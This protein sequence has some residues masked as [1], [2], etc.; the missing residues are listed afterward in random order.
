M[1]AISVKKRLHIHLR[2][3]DLGHFGFSYKLEY[4]RAQFDTDIASVTLFCINNN[5]SAL[6]AILDWW[7]TSSFFWTLRSEKT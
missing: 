3:D 7:S 6:D 4:F 2:I 1:E 5:A